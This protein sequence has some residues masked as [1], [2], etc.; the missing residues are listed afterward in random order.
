MK[1][2]LSCRSFQW[3]KLNLPVHNFAFL[4][5]IPENWG[6]PRDSDSSDKSCAHTQKDSQ[7][8]KAFSTKSVRIPAEHNAME[9]QNIFG[10]STTKETHKHNCINI[11]TAAFFLL[12]SLKKSRKFG[13]NRQ[14]WCNRVIAVVIIVNPFECAAGAE[15]VPNGSIYVEIE[16]RSAFVSARNHKTW[17]L[18]LRLT[19]SLAYALGLRNGDDDIGVRRVDT[20]KGMELP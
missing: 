10:S 19:N 4:T 6:F 18:I 5:K 16:M 15:G 20:R 12:T 9:V 7:K 14:K 3:Q 1:Q 13:D 2:P 17:P 8:R 11:S